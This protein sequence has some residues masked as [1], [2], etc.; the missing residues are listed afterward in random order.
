VRQEHRGHDGRAELGQELQGEA[1]WRALLLYLGE[2]QL[3]QRDCRGAGCH[4]DEDAEGRERRGELPHRH[5]RVAGPVLVNH[6]G[7]AQVHDESGDRHLF[8]RPARD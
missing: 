1:R 8:N 7:G 5:Q 3:H 4:R 2:H 6:E